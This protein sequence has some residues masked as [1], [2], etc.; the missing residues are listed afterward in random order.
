MQVLSCS[1]LL[2][3]GAVGVFV[4]TVGLLWAK[5]TVVKNKPAVKIS[6]LMFLKFRKAGDHRNEKIK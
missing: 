4:F 6:V 2:S 3:V 5:K 1:F